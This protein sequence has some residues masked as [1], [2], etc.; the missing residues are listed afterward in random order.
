LKGMQIIGGL[1]VLSFLLSACQTTAGKKTMDTTD[2]ELKLNLS[3]EFLENNYDG[4][5]QNLSHLTIQNCG[6]IPLPSSGWNL[7][8]NW[9]RGLIPNELPGSLKGKHLNGDFYQISPTKDFPDLAPGASIVLPIVGTHWQM[10]YTDAPSGLYLVFGEE[11]DEPQ[12]IPLDLNVMAIQNERAFTKE[13]DWDRYENRYNAY[14]EKIIPLDAAKPVVIPTPVKLV[15]G[16][17]MGELPSPFRFWAPPLAKN[18]ADLLIFGWKARFGDDV[19][20]P[21]QVKKR[22][23]ADLILRID[24]DAFSK[25]TA[26]TGAYHLE[27]SIADFPKNEAEQRK[28]GMTKSVL[29]GYDDSGLFYSVQTWLNILPLN[30]QEGEILL[31]ALEIRDYPRFPYRGM[32]VDVAR[33]FRTVKE[34]KKII[35]LMALYKLNVLHFHLTDDEGW[36][37]EIP[38]LP[39]LTEIGAFRGHPLKGSET[40]LPSLGSG[41]FPEPG[42]SNGS[43]FYSQKEYIDLLHY[44]A[45][46]KIRVIPEL[47]FPGHAR[48]AIQAMEVRSKRLLAEGRKEEAARFALTHPQDSSKYISIQK[49]RGNVVDVCLESTYEF[50]DTVVASLHKLY[51]EAGLDL[52]IIHIGGDEVPH[53]AWS[54]SPVCQA[55]MA[56]HPEYQKYSNLSRYFVLRLDNILKKYDIQTAGWEDI[57]VRRDSRKP[58][59]D[60]SLT[61]L[62]LLPYVWNSVWGWGA[63]DLSN[64]FANKGFETILANVTNLYFDL[65]YSNDPAEPGFYWGGYVNTR[66]AW[67]FTPLNLKNCAVYDGGG[68]RVDLEKFHD[69][70]AL[71]PD[72]AKNLL[73]LQGLL[74]GENARTMHQFEYF[75]FP[76][77]IGMAER[78]WAAVPEWETE[79]ADAEKEMAWR[80]FANALGQKELPRLDTFWGGVHYRLPDPKA[81]VSEG[82]LKLA[83][84]FP[85]L[86]VRY[87]TDGSIP[88]SKSAVFENE[89]TMKAGQIIKLAVFDSRGRSGRVV[90]IK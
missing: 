48:A 54:G 71:L 40:L 18:E 25:E 42:L 17:K 79:A 68:N 51:S 76:K 21:I 45:E 23:E 9:C 38:A 37:I 50:M 69:Y 36:R 7:Y 41:P 32:H 2:K 33:S 75:L 35:D 55:F 49:F 57:A 24:P 77:L 78:A 16:E 74:W 81:I 62:N 28:E 1:V 59:P 65:A 64:R 66:S 10:N 80:F 60:T 11:T 44:A 30:I 3:W 4:K 47:D 34:M 88:N 15:Y 14:V 87:T 85:G 8:F 52:D 63:E 82:I 22:E 26:K 67:E 27:I 43:G 84:A 31:P 73:G 20:L 46:R 86:T 70:Q 29:T 89:L 53:G 72:S 19:P 61:Q 6:E 56:E 58:L 83:H 5:S 13:A 12:I 39:E 90:E